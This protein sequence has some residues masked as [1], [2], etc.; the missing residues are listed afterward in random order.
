MEGDNKRMQWVE[1]RLPS[2]REFLRFIGWGIGRIIF[3]IWMFVLSSVRVLLKTALSIID[4]MEK[5][6]DKILGIYDQLPHS[7]ISHHYLTHQNQDD[8]IQLLPVTDILAEIEGKQLMIIGEMGTGKSTIAQYLAYT[9]GTKVKV[10][11]CE[12][13]PDDWAGLEVIGKGEDWSAIEEGMQADL[14]DLSNQMKIR[15]QRGDNALSGTEKVIICEEYPEL[16]NKV[17]SSGEWL[18]RHARRGRK[19]RRFTILLSQYD[20]VGAWGLEGK[21]DLAEAFFR[22]RLGKKAVSHARSLKNNKLVEWLKQDR[23]HCLL[24]DYPCILPVYREMKAV[25][26]R[27][28]PAP[29]NDQIKMAVTQSKPGLQPFLTENN[30][31]ENPITGVVKAC[32]DADF[33][34]SRII[35]EVLGYKGTSYQAGKQLLEDIKRS[36]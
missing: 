2:S 6:T 35:K 17:P 13:T 19:A 20:R 16:V 1:L 22:I 8:S 32:L 3:S 21:A 28:L 11:E 7:G 27:L 30:I 26:H 15:N 34:D 25:T 24:D 31:R 36:L 9:V 10:Y 14:D 5:G 4:Q 12:G 18:E 29:Q 23:R 33:S